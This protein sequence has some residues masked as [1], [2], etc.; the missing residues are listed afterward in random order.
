MAAAG[1]AA[2]LGL[3]GAGRAVTSA[4]SLSGAAQAGFKQGGIGGALKATI[5]QPAKD[6]GSR[7]SAPVRDAYREGSAYGFSAGGGGASPSAP[8]GRGKSGAS[9]EPDWARRIR[10]REQMTRAGTVASQSIREG[11]RGSASEGPSLDPD[12]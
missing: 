5:G 1:A 9:P 8:P 10:R 11:D 6:M 12:S 7:A 2:R 3:S 4:A